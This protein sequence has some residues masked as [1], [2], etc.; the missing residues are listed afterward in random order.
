MDKWNRLIFGISTNYYRQVEDENGKEITI[1]CEDDKYRRYKD[2][3]DEMR[4]AH[5]ARP[6]VNK[7][8]RGDKGIIM[9]RTNA[10]DFVEK[11]SQR[12]DRERGSELGRGQSAGHEKIKKVMN[13][14]KRQSKTS[15]V[16]RKMET[17]K[18]NQ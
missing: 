13:G 15:L 6:N 12:L 11:P 7:I 3:L 18:F 1:A 9:P 10:F 4:L 16:N 17:V 14:V 8:H 2:K 5:D